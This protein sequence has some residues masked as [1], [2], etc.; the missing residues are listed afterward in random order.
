MP[1]SFLVGKIFPPGAME[2]VAQEL[3]KNEE[4]PSQENEEQGHE[5]VEAKDIATKEGVQAAEGVAKE[6]R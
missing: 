3:K 4:Q 2:R 6:L 5:M 1:S